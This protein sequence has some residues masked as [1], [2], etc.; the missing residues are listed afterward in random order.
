MAGLV[1]GAVAP[2]ILFAAL[3]LPATASAW[4]VT[5]KVHGAGTVEDV[6]KEGNDYEQLKL[7]NCT[8][9]PA[10]KH[11]GSVTNCVGG[12]L[13]GLW[14]W[15]NTVRLRAA[16]GTA[17]ASRGWVFSHWADGSAGGQVN[18]DGDDD[19]EHTSIDCDF[20]IFDN[21]YIDVYFDDTQGPQDTSI[22]ST[23]RSGW[24]PR[25]ACS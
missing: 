7:Q 20:R 21:L 9:G 25:S 22:T 3:A 6:T 4:T 13:D 17:A 18:C 24:S 15:G 11:E 8:I 2:L 5:V 19:G 23:P 16:P 1:R 14:N 12:T 10:G